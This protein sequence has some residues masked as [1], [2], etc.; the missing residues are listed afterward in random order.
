MAVVDQRDVQRLGGR[1]ALYPA[2]YIVVT[3]LERRGLFN[4]VLDVT[5]GR[6]RFYA[7]RRP[8]FLVGADPRVWEWIVAPDIFIPKPV[9]AVK[10]VLKHMNVRF[11]VVV[12]D[13]PFRQGTTYS[14]RDEYGYVL[15]TP[16]LI[17]EKTIELARELGI[18]YMLLHYSELIDL[19]IVENIE[20]RYVSRYLNN[21]GL[22]TTTYF[23]LYRVGSRG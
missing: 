11:D 3:L 18:G 19:P 10:S 20:F 21:P 12:C 1:A 8:R 17:I 23:T 13:P 2:S 4:R 22:R 14:D 16:R 6:G 5:Y 7:Y 9:W 15:G